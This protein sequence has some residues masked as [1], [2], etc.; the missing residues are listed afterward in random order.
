MCV[1]V[2]TCECVCVYAHEYESECVYMCVWA[3][4]H[5]CLSVGV[6]FSVC[7][8]ALGVSRTDPLFMSGSFAGQ[9]FPLKLQASCEPHCVNG[10]RDRPGPLRPSVVKDQ[11]SFPCYFLPIMDQYIHAAKSLQSCLTLSTLEWVAISFS[12][13]WKW[14]VKVKSLSRVQ[15]LVTPWTT[16]YQTPPSMGFPAIWNT[17]VQFLGWEDPLGKGMASHSNILAWRNPW[18]EESGRL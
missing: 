7:V 3:C 2:C 4:I 8:C 18:T 14:K 6:G 16:A 12:N 17:W 1:Y 10:E 15:L 13:P 5:E 11:G 9:W